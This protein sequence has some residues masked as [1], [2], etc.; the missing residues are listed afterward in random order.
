MTVIAVCTY[1]IKTFNEVISGPTIPWLFS[2]SCSRRR[3]RR[4]HL[5]FQHPYRRQLPTYLR[6][7]A[8]L[9]TAACGDDK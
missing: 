4:R 3:R 7:D 5:T 2:S 9:F 6:A 1:T 8:F